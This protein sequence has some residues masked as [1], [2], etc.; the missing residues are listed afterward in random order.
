MVAAITAQV[1]DNP[2]PLNTVLICV[3]CITVIVLAAVLMLVFALVVRGLAWLLAPRAADTDA[4]VTALS[5]PALAPVGSRRCSSCGK[6]LPAD[7]PQGLCPRCLLQFAIEPSHPEPASPPTAAYS[8][9]AMSLNTQDVAAQFPQ[10]EVI[11]LLGAGGMGAVYKARQPHLDRL[12]ALKVLPPASARDPAFAERFARE[13]R[14]LARLNHPHIVGVHDFG[15]SGEHYFLLMEYVDGVNL[16]HAM[17]AGQLT[18]GEALRIVPQLCDALQFAHDEGVVHRDIK[19]ENILLDKRGRV[20]VADFGLAK[21][22][23]PA[24]GDMS[25]TGTQQVMGTMHYMAPEQLAGAKAVDHR[26]DIYSLGVTFYEM[27]TGELP[28]GR[29]PPPSQ[30]AGIDAR[31]DQVVL[32]TL[33]R[34]PANRYQ[35]ASDVKIEVESIVHQSASALPQDHPPLQASPSRGQIRRAGNWMLA[36]GIVTMLAWVPTILLPS[37][38]DFNR[39]Q[40]ERLEIVIAMQI[41]SLLAGGI[42]TRG[43]MDMRQVRGYW[44][45]FT[46]AVLA[47]VPFSLSAVIALPIGVCTLVLLRRRDVQNEFE[48]TLWL[49]KNRE[50]AASTATIAGRRPETAMHALGWVVGRLVRGTAWPRMLSIP[51]CLLGASTLLGSWVFVQIDAHIANGPR[52]SDG[53][54][55][56]FLISGRELWQAWAIC[57]TFFSLA[58]V[59]IATFRQRVRWPGL[60]LL[61]GSAAAGILTAAVLNQPPVPGNR[62][63]LRQA[64]QSLHFVFPEDFPARGQTDLEVLEEASRMHNIVIQENADQAPAV[65]LIVAGVL[66]LLAVIDVQRSLST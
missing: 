47:M 7:A 18:A 21:M 27:L 37:F 25:L 41:W 30:T 20:K 32:R 42:I 55:A 8:P 23:G 13:A 64:V 16:R 3:A 51:L 45:A 53:R 52:H 63:E 48:R 26:A 12:V 57:G 24:A 28:L 11:E 34:E 66:V 15:R 1:V 9:G 4:D 58:G 35:H 39:A 62:P 46:G 14:A 19:P 36:A 5:S 44:W 59:A 10:L 2:L 56:S 33:E 65:A 61:L 38:V 49:A 54:W 60:V 17:R 31:L 6:P 22:L 50:F 29:F 40:V 43:G